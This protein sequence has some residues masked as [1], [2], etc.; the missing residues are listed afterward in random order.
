M[1]HYNVIDATLRNLPGT[2]RGNLEVWA[3]GEQLMAEAARTMDPDE[4]KRVG[5]YLRDHLDPD[6][7]F[8][9]SDRQHKRELSVS[10]QGA[11]K[12]AAITGTLDPV[13][14]ALWDVVAAKWA[15]AG[16]N[17]PNDPDSPSG[18]AD[19]ADKDT[20][21]A[22]A[23]RDHRTPG[24]RNHDVGATRTRNGVWPPP[25]RVG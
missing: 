11:D 8:D 20:V 16:M 14:K 17:N 7:E 9:D 25:P 19:K 13:T 22:A 1:A 18:P 5:L 24:Q 15:A 4:L 10:K 12:M 23:A 21:R 6:G 2:I 3:Q